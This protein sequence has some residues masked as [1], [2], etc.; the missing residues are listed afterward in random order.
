MW[1]FASASILAGT[2]AQEFSKVRSQ[3]TV[4]I[5][6]VILLAGI[7]DQTELDSAEVAAIEHLDCLTTGERGYNL[8]LGGGG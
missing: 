4:R 5:V 6:G 2:D 1:T 3:S 8:Q 7:Q